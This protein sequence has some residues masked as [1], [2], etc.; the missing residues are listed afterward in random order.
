MQQ[1]LM[2]YPAFA[3]AL[4]TFVVAIWLLRCRIR[5]VRTGLTPIYFNLN[6]GAKLPSYLV[7]ATQHY[8]NLFEMPILF[9]V[10]II[11][12][13]ITQ[14]VDGLLIALAWGYVGARFIHTVI[15]LGHNKVRHRLWAFLLSYALLVTMWV[16]L[17][18]KLLI[19]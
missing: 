18:I 11:I 13:Y 17:F 10:A 14:Q 2:L 4:L 6:R 7:Q 5:A 3:M 1:T 19:A 15:H 16:W 8:D 12:I 9:Y